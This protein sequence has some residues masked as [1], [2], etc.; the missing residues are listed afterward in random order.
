MILEKLE[1]LERRLDMLVVPVIS[2]SAR[3]VLGA[4]MATIKQH[5]KDLLKRK[6]A[7]YRGMSHA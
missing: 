2:E 1:R 3:Q 7:E 6:R 4:D 5:N